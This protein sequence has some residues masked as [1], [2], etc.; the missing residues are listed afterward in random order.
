MKLKLRMTYSI[1]VLSNGRAAR[2]IIFDSSWPIFILINSSA[3][4]AHTIIKQL[5]K[6]R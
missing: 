1:I 3:N 5:K 6:Q 4:S 2:L